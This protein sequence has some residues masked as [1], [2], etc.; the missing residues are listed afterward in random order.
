MVGQ[1]VV[2]RA[3]A[4]TDVDERQALGRHAEIA[5]MFGAATPGTSP[6]SY[7]AA[8]AWMAARGP[9]GTVEWIVEAE[10]RFLG[11]ARLHSFDGRGG[12]RYAIGLL[13]PDRLGQG[14]GTE[15]TELI[16]EYAFGQLGLKRVEAAV[17]EI[18]RR[19][20]RAFQRCGFRPMGR[21]PRAAVIDG[22][23]RDEVL[24][25]ARPE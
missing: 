9:E 8:A 20:I 24:M 14:L 13:D 10:G 3:P 4:A 6:M 15:T 5:R 17:L 19:A 25:E 12:A 7:E 22:E 1:R 11:T 2:L 21:L 16:L 18:N 23:P